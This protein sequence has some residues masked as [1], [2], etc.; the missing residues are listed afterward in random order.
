M[1]RWW[2]RLILKGYQC[3]WLRKNEP[4]KAHQDPHDDEVVVSSSCSD[5]TQ[6]SADD[7][8][9]NGSKEDPLPAVHLC[10]SAS[11]YLSEEVAPEI[12]AQNQALLGL[13]PHQ[14]SIFVLQM[15]KMRNV[16]I[17]LTPMDGGLH[18][19]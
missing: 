13:A 17:Y 14:G 1:I 15:F 3:N 18:Q 9:H 16:A 7:V 12:G 19:Q 6:E 2:Q 4:T 11:G 10:H 8:D 5:G